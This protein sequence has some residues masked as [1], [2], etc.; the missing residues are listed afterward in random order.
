MISYSSN[1]KG[2]WNPEVYNN[3]ENIYKEAVNRFITLP[4]FKFL[5]DYKVE[6]ILTDNQWE[7]VSEIEIKFKIKVGITRRKSYWTVVKTI[8][9]P[10]DNNNVILVI[11]INELP[12]FNDVNKID[13]DNISFV[14]ASNLIGI[15]GSNYLPKFI[16]E[17][18]Y[19]DL[20]NYKENFE[21]ILFQCLDNLLKYIKLEGS[22]LKC[23]FET[24]PEP[25]KQEFMRNVVDAHFK[26]QHN[27]DITKFNRTIALIIKEYL[28]RSIELDLL[29][30]KWDKNDYLESITSNI[31]YESKIQLEKIISSPSMKND[32]FESHILEL[33]KYCFINKSEL[34]ETIFQ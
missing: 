8:I 1:L 11:N 6:I 7:T 32:N 25:F 30:Y 2:K 31:I 12:L 27:G 22:G 28:E 13:T 21:W 33:L 23:N 19:L 34:D 5:N 14:I 3:I 4:T 9:N 18:R 16:S 24:E 26:Y 20:S 15:D 29:G 17:Q 10:K